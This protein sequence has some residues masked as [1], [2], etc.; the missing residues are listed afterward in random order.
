MCHEELSHCLMQLQQSI[1]FRLVQ[2]SA[3]PPK[4]VS[5]P[6]VLFQ[7]LRFP[8]RQNLCNRPPSAGEDSTTL[9]LT[10]LNLIWQFCH[11]IHCPGWADSVHQGRCSQQILEKSPPPSLLCPPKDFSGQDLYWES[12]NLS[13]LSQKRQ[14]WKPV[15]QM[16]EQQIPFTTISC[17]TL[18]M[19]YHFGDKGITRS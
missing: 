15:N 2:F 19:P 13:D 11:P 4:I 17:G 8:H 18:S 12:Y 10:N 7:S 1:I 9:H 3:L 6:V 5:A 14:L 16:C